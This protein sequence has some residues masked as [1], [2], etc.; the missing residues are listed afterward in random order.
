[1]GDRQ[2]CLY[3]S[4]SVHNGYAYCYDPTHDAKWGYACY[5]PPMGCGDPPRCPEVEK[6]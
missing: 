2:V 4:V 3:R 6:R 5:C 1:M